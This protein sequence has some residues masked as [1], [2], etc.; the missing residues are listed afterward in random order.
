MNKQNPQGKKQK[1]KT[2]VLDLEPG[3]LLLIIA[4]LLLAPLLLAGFFSH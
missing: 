3:T 1:D 4:V 2:I